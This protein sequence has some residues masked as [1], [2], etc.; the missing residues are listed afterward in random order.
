MV[1]ALLSMDTDGLQLNL[2][3]GNIHHTTKI[4]II[5]LHQIY[6]YEHELSLFE[7]NILFFHRDSFELK[8]LTQYVSV[9][10][11]CH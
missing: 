4:Y 6:H 10:F 3:M 7:H 5:P 8:G 2:Q 9:F 11:L 1:E